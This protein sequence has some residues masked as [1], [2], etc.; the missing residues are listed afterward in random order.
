[1]EKILGKRENDPIDP[2]STMF[3]KVGLAAAETLKVICI[4]EVFKQTNPRQKVVKRKF[5]YFFRCSRRYSVKNKIV[6]LTLS[7]I[8]FPWTH[9]GNDFRMG[10][11]GNNSL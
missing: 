2:F 3:T 8:S 7:L 6:Y 9:P 11:N 1:M 4:R 10:S 5:T